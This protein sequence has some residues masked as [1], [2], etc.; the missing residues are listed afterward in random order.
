MPIGS[1]ILSCEPG[2][3]A[4]LT[5][6]ILN[7]DRIRHAM[8]VIT[9]IVYWKRHGPTAKNTASGFGNESLDLHVNR[10]H[11]FS[12]DG[13]NYF[14][15]RGS[16]NVCAILGRISNLEEMKSRHSISLK[17]DVEVIETLYGVAGLGGLHQ[18]E[19]SFLLFFWDGTK[20]KG[21]ILTDSFGYSLPMYYVSSKDRLVFSTSLKEI[22]KRIPFNR[23]LNMDVVCDF[24]IY[25]IGS[26][27]KCTLIKHV[28]KLLTGQ[29]LLINHSKKSVKAKY[30]RR[31]V[32][33]VPIG[34]AKKN[35]IASLRQ[36]IVSL[37]AEMRHKNVA[38][39][40]SSGYDSNILLHFLASLKDLNVTAWTID[41]GRMNEI[42]EARVM[43]KRYE[44]VKHKIRV[45]D[46]RSL[47]NIPDVVW[48]LEGA[49][50]SD[51][52]FLGFEYSRLI[53]EDSKIVF[54]GSAAEF[55]LNAEHSSPVALSKRNLIN[56]LFYIKCILFNKGPFKRFGRGRLLLLKRYARTPFLKLLLYDL[57]LYKAMK[58]WGLLYNG[59]GL[60][61]IRPFLNERTRALSKPLINLNVRR[62][63]YEKEVKRVL[64]SDMARHLYNS[65]PIRT[66]EFM[67]KNL[68][69]IMKLFK[70]DFIR[71]LLDK[72]TT[73]RMVRNPR[74]HHSSILCLLHL[75]LFNEL[76]VSG[77]FDPM[78]DKPYFD[79]KLDYFFRQ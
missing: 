19:G 51:E 61:I 7:E 26:P 43:A 12:S 79:R 72:E 52:V 5:A 11:C 9:G 49:I 20:R 38:C 68:A 29:H 55:L 42:S 25:G 60:V 32:K 8:D 64:G 34:Y 1:P 18:L 66:L 76:F 37:S 22:L 15:N 53:K 41:G 16:G 63:F 4:G 3:P 40:F 48:R 30:S 54:S 36:S 45:L 67:D 56:E 14:H 78:F 59:A 31:T 44:H 50:H 46:S 23:E 73:D 74:G 17:D 33:K 75:Y 24:L 47:E 39:L 70:T 6:K 77:K 62:A 13:K 27:T 71:R 21:I 28:N 69:L 65:K 35:L 58:R 10:I 2:V 57:N